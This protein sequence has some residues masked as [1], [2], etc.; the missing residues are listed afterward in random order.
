MLNNKTVLKIISVVIAVC[1]WVYVIGEIDPESRKKI[2]SIE[3]SYANT[4]VLAESGLAVTDEETVM[5]SAV[6]EGKRSDLNDVKKRGITASVDVSKCKEGTNTLDVAVNLPDGVKLDSVS[7]TRIQVNV[8]ELVSEERPVE[9]SI[10]GGDTESGKLPWVISYKPETVYVKGAANIVSKVDHVEGAVDSGEVTDQLKNVQV[11]LIPVDKAG[12]EVNGLELSYEV[13]FADV[14]MLSSKR[15]E[16]AIKTENLSENMEIDGIH[17]DKKVWIV[18]QETALNAIDKITG[19]V[20]LSGMTA[21]GKAE[22]I[23]DLPEGV[24]LYNEEDTAVAEVT[25]KPLSESDSTR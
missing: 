4:D 6:I 14:Q 20:D 15:V 3:V 25:L 10:S 16:M 17:A 23:I 9:I 8:G 18:G 2:N 1:L 21:S 7:E 11:S 24:Y 13:A 12:D 22:I 19:T 5:I